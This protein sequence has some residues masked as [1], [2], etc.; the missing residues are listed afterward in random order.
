[1][2]RKCQ[3]TGKRPRKG[4]TYSIR[5]IAKKKKGIGL[6]ICGQAK[7]RFKPNLFK[8]KLWNP[9]TRQFI[10]LRLSADALRTIDKKGIVSV[11][12]NAGI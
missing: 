2:A 12:K 3:I 1:M 9:E 7:R 8:K 10:T 4:K 11:L 6:N 5:R